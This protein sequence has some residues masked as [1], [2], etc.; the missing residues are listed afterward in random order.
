MK[1]SWIE[2]KLESLWRNTGIDSIMAMELTNQLE[3]LFGSL[4]KT[5]FFEY[6]TIQEIADYFVRSY[7]GRLREI[8]GLNE[9]TGGVESAGPEGIIATAFR[10]QSHPSR[11]AS[12]Q[13]LSLATPESNVLDIAIIGLSGRYPQARDLE[14]YWKNLCN[15]KDC[16]SEVPS[17]RWDWREYYSEDRN[18]V[19]RHYS[20]WGGFIEDVDRFDPLFFNISPREA[21]LLDPQERLFLEAVWT[22]VEDAGYSSKGLVGEVSDYLSSQ[23]GVYAGVM[24]GEYQLFGA[25][26]S[27]RGN[28]RS[29]NSIYAA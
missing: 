27:L 18:Q 3:K 21:A 25:E 12:I 26:A 20:K 22:A 23:V 10:E 9:G 7:G 17:D 28:Q 8:L 1:L 14:Q 5:L 24:Y 6:Q 29:T 19:G 16:I 11:F 13:K 4:S 2:S 15:S